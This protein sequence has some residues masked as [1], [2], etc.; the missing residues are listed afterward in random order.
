MKKLKVQEFKGWLTQHQKIV[1]FVNENNIQ[2]EDILKLIFG[3]ANNFLLFYFS[4]EEV[5]E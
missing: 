1:E 5:A 2:Q 3:P 4:D